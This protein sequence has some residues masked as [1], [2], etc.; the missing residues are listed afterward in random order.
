M[1]E[2]NLA[3]DPAVVELEYATGVSTTGVS[4]RM[5]E[6]T[7]VPSNRPKPATVSSLDT[8]SLTLATRPGI[9]PPLI[10][11]KSNSS[12]TSAGHAFSREANRRGA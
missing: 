5:A 6:G 3:N 1:G 10:V 9:T 8:K 2:L 7:M 11:A 12:N 4:T